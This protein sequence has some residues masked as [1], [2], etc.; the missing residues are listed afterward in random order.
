[1]AGPRTSRVLAV[2]FVVGAVVVL[3]AALLALV[4]QPAELVFPFLTPGLV[5][6]L[7]LNAAMAD[8][9]GAVNMTLGALANGLVVGVVAVL[10]VRLWG[11][12][13]GWRTPP[14]PSSGPSRPGSPTPS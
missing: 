1:M 2:G 7:P 12:L 13:R 14:T 3:P 4:W 6:L 8:W 9:P 10:L 5:L 11:M